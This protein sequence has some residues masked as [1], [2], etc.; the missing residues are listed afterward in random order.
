MDTKI[1]QVVNNMKE[2]SKVKNN[3]ESRIK[4]H[5]PENFKGPEFE[6]CSFCHEVHFDTQYSTC[7]KCREHEVSK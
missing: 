4:Y 5:L 3:I 6:Q 1:V 7:E 2:N